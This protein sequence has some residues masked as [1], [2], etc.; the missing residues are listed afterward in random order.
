MQAGT[1]MSTQMMRLYSDEYSDDETVDTDYVSWIENYLSIPGHDILV[2][3]PDS[4]IEDPFNLQDLRHKI[5]E[6]DIALQMILDYDVS[7][8]LQM[9]LD[10]DVR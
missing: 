1:L 4:Y 3:V 5:P 10:Y 6:Y 2:Q 9:T 7:I 8:A